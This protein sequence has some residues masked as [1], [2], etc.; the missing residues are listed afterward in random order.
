MR[1]DVVLVCGFRLL[2]YDQK[3]AKRLAKRMKKIDFYY[4]EQAR[5]DAGFFIAEVIDKLGINKSTYY[6]WKKQ[7][8]APEWAWKLLK[9]YGGNLDELG[10]KHWQ[11]KEKVLYNRQLSTKYYN[12]IEADLMVSVFCGCE[13]H[14]RIRAIKA[15]NERN[16]KAHCAT[17]SPAHIHRSHA[18]RHA[19]DDKNHSARN[20]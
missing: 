5:H 11:I 7:K 12:W 16:T 9:M 2:R 1:S 15:E 6:H 10:W 8:Q 20:G 19:L 13:N 3:K 17:G 18:S 14:K 4:I